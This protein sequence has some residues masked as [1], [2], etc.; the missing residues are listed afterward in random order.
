MRDIRKIFGPP[1]TGKTT[2]LLSIVEEAMANRVQPE[3]IA[4][5]SFTKKASDEA[6]TRAKE[7]FGFREERMPWFKTLHSMAFHA[8]HARRD[9]IMQEDHFQELGRILGFQFTSLDDEYSMMPMGTA[10]GDKAARIEALS[11]V[12]QVSLQQQWDDSNYRDVNWEAVEQWSEGLKKFKHERGMMDY[13][14]LLEQFDETID[15]DMFIIDEAQDLS[16]LQWNVVRK[17]ARNAKAI[18]L[19]GDDDQCI[20]GW[21]GADVSRFLRMKATT[22]V[23]PVSFRLPAKVQRLANRVSSRIQVR[24]EKAWESRAE[25][26][27]VDYTRSETSLNLSEGTWLL[28]CRNRSFLKRYVELLHMSGYSYMKDGRH[29][30]DNAVTRGIMAWEAWRKGRAVKPTEVKAIVALLPELEKF[31]P[32]EDVLMKD[33]P[34]REATRKKNWMEALDVEPRQRE[35]I[36]ACLSNGE[37]LTARPRITISTIHMAKG[38]EADHVALIPDITQQPWNA[39]TGD[40]E[41]RADEEQRVLYVGITRA[42]QSLTILQPQTNRHYTI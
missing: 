11:R 2:R 27:R 3:R 24:Q 26:G 7:R 4:Y 10:L 35:Y 33:A 1:G 38:G 8:V 28:L 22:E 42:R 37:R 41:E 16:P 15:V 17:A 40:N 12:R 23:L 39:L 9:D 30:T 34:L 21:A 36:R 20:Y 19:A 32:R 13:N 25:E 29:S 14:D 18:Y 6:I 5:M 31:S